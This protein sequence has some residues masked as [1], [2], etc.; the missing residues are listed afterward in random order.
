V[1]RVLGRRVAVLGAALIGIAG[2]SLAIT[3]A[4]QASAC[5]PNGVGCTQSG[6]YQGPNA[7]ISSNYSGF[8]VVWTKSEV[9]PYSSGVPLYWTAYITYT[10]VSG[11]TLDL[12][13]PGQWADPAT[14][15]EIMSGGSGDDGL[16]SAQDT[17]CSQNPALDQPV[18][19]GGTFTSWA[20]FH[21][22][23]WPG[24]AV[25]VQW[26]DAG[27]SPAVYPFGDQSAAQPPPASTRTVY[28]TPWNGYVYNH[29]AYAVGATFTVPKLDCP[30]FPGL[31]WPAANPWVGMGGDTATASPLVQ[32]GILSQ[33]LPLGFQHSWAVW[34]V[35]PARP[36]ATSYAHR[37]FSRSASPGDV[38]YASVI[39]KGGDTFYLAVTDTNA[40]HGWHWH[41]TLTESTEHGAPTSAEWIV[42]AGG[43]ALADFH[44]VTF[45]ASSYAPTATGGGQLITNG[46]AVKFIQGTASRPCT[47]V[48][49]ISNGLFNVTYLRTC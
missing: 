39:Y 26:G 14:M 13:C 40:K 4:S 44:H 8:R 35:I 48:G 47:S 11:Q 38:I 27:T 6:T 43:P 1:S 20:T 12:G 25:S 3:P 28:Q 23:P 15:A 21:N 41:M 46:N 22:V 16:V 37:V 7:V 9:E 49:P 34:E 30:R 31:Y 29:T 17:S 19:P 2:M 5:Q 33:C 18:A 10:N 42:E 45:I 36:G 32:D 24:S